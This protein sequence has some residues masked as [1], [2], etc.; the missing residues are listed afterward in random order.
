MST[1]PV[2]Q[3]VG[4]L[5][6]GLCLDWGLLGCS[7]VQTY[8][9]YCLF[10]NDRRSLKS[11]VYFLYLWGVVQTL[12]FTQQVFD[13]LAK[14]WG[15]PIAL[16]AKGTLWFSV[17]IMSGVA[18]T[19]VQCFY[20]WRVLRL[21]KSYFLSVVIVV[22]ALMEGSS[23]IALGFIGRFEVQSLAE[24]QSKTFAVTSVWLLGSAICDVVIG[25]SMVFFLT[26]LR[27]DSFDR[28][29]EN[30]VTRLVRLCVGAGVITAVVA[31]I[32]S[33]LYIAYIHNNYHFAPAATLGKLYVNSLLVLLNSRQRHIADD[34]QRGGKLWRSSRRTVDIRPEVAEEDVSMTSCNS[35]RN[36]SGD[37]KPGDGKHIV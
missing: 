11:L 7:S 10:P 16:E 34:P 37:P 5:I 4:P 26:R 12:L 22:L 17:P 32:D 1:T 29:A 33:A 6:I 21:S 3:L 27:H 19:V 20:S 36:S 14:G 13:N 23:S 24:L 9:Y 15:S 28:A 2:V 30:L 18:S 35:T 25:A 31:I 8:Y